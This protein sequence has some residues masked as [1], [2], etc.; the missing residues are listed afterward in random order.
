[1]NSKKHFHRS[2][3]I[4]ILLLIV[5]NTYCQTL[6]SEKFK[7]QI[8]S[9]QIIEKTFKMLGN[10]KII[11]GVISVTKGK[12]T[13][14]YKY[15]APLWKD[16]IVDVALRDKKDKELFPKMWYDAKEKMFSFDEKEELAIKS[17]NYQDV[18][19]SA[20]LIWAKYYIK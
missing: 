9:F 14:D 18:I 8:R 20:V 5:G 1:M 17:A 11:L 7:V 12:K 6:E 19:M 2:I 4:I 15:F 16:T 13:I 3:L 10:T